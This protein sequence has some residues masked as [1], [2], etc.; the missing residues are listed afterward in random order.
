LALALIYDVIIS[1]DA[2][3]SPLPERLGIVLMRSPRHC[4]PGIF[5]FTFPLVS[6]AAADVSGFLPAVKQKN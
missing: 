4:L 1:R 6:E 5:P 2:S 3:R